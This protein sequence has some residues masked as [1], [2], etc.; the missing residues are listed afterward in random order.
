MPQT[1][2]SNMIF[3]RLFLSFQKIIDI[4]CYG[5]WNSQTINEGGVRRHI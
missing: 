5:S 2:L 4:G 3:E 1:A